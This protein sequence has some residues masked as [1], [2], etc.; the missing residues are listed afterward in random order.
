MKDISRFKNIK[1]FIFDVDGVLTDGS[2]LVTEEGELLRRMN[3]RDGQA[4]KYAL[5]TGFDVAIITK[6]ASKGVRKRLEILGITHLYDAVIDK[7][8]AIQDLKNELKVDKTKCLYMGD[9]IPDLA[10]RDEVS[11]FTCPRDASPQVVDV[12]DYIAISQ[13]GHGCVRE[14]IEKTM[15][16]QELWPLIS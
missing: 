15:R 16:A 2:L 4:I 8:I 1:C 6:G 3:V 7:R 9:D 14:V 10:V 5:E 13:G 11:I 12:A